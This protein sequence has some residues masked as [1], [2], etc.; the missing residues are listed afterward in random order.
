MATKNQWT[1]I[2]VTPLTGMLD[3]RSRPA[4]LPPGAFRYKTNMQATPEGKMCRRGGFTKAFA[5]VTGYTNY[6]HHHQNAERELITFGYEATKSDGTRF[7][8]DGTES[9]ISVLNEDTGFW[10]DIAS[11]YGANGSKWRA[12]LLQD[13]MVFTNNVDPPLIHSLGSG[14]TATIP[15]LTARG[16]TSALVVFQ[17]NGIMVLANVVQ[18]GVHHGYR[19]V[20]S[21]LNDASAWAIAPP[22]SLA[23]Y[24]D[25]DFGDDILAAAPL[26]G[27]Y[28][29]Y[30]RR[31]IWRM[32]VSGDTTRVFSFTRVYNEPKNQE[33]CLAFP[34]TLVSDGSSHYYMSRNAVFRFNNYLPAPE[35]K[36]DESDWLHR[37]T[38][39]I[40]KKA[41]TMM[42]QTNCFAP[43]AEYR[44]S[45]KELW[46]SWPAVNRTKNSLTL[47]A[48]LDQKTADLVD[49]GF[50][51]MLNYRRKAESAAECNEVQSFLAV[52]SGPY[53]DWCWK[54]IGG[55]FYR[56][57]ATLAGTLTDDIDDIATYVHRGYN[58]ILRGMIPTG[59]YDREKII[60]NIL[61]DDDVSEQTPPVCLYRLRIGH[62]YALQDPN[63]VDDLCSVMW[64]EEGTRQVACIDEA[65]I[66]VLQANG[67]KPAITKEWRVFRQNR[68]L[69]WELTVQGG[70]LSGEAPLPASSLAIGG[71]TC[72][73][74]VDFDVMA[75]PKP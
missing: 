6:D 27:S 58:S 31:S 41:D 66:S 26:G 52:A 36:I 24:Q 35:Y 4:D 51:V 25:L 29:L 72:L 16:V 55:V 9:R 34:Y 8:F 75:M 60:R 20:W 74:R 13:D 69:Y 73:N 2:S 43:V 63:D 30:T 57:Y 10:Q 47:V 37:A 42:N 12:A 32:A 1:T 40:Y 59:L 45:T 33:G 5:D 7:L 68:F 49:E 50:S 39:L 62:S 21:D 3:V 48:N 71:D 14:T 28:Y 53:G 65:R 70:S 67:K 19:L 18:T 56:E 54:D 44:P 38:G 17:F 11:G 22:D 46:F 23:N 15:E 64:N 61:L